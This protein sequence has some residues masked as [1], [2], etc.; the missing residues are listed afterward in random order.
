MSPFL[1]GSGTSNQRTSILLEV[2]AKAETLVGPQEGTVKQRDQRGEK[3]MPEEPIVCR[4]FGKNI[5]PMVHVC[6]YIYSLLYDKDRDAVWVI[7]YGYIV[8]GILCVDIASHILVYPPGLLNYPRKKKT[9]TQ[10]WAFSLLWHSS[11]DIMHW[12]LRICWSEWK[13]EHRNSTFESM[14]SQF[15]QTPSIPHYPSVW[16]VV[17]RHK[18]GEREKKCLCLNWCG[19]LKGV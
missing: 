6:L 3:I 9:T 5:F 1:S 10:E 19:L 14:C 2:V 7:C 4:V 15:S 12:F 8:C 16:R 18:Q 17:W 13:K 11:L